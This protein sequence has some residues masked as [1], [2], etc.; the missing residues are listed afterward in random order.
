MPKESELSYS[1]SS[2]HVNDLQPLLSPQGDENQPGTASIRIL[3]CALRKELDEQ[4]NS[5]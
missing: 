3:A 1:F 4:E 2:S 5:E